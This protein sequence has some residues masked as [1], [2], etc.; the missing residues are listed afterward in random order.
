[1]GDW[2]CPYS[3]IS[4]RNAAI[5]LKPWCWDQ[6]GRSALRAKAPNWSRNFPHSPWDT[7]LDRQLQPQLQAKPLVA[8]AV[9]AVDGYRSEPCA[10]IYVLLYPNAS[11]SKPSIGPAA[12]NLLSESQELTDCRMKHHVEIAGTNAKLIVIWAPDAIVLTAC[13][14]YGKQDNE[15]KRTY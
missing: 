6:L 14:D 7:T 8:A 11:K 15:E 5:G 9:A 1:M 4:A 13:S 10:R 2:L 3:N 12:L